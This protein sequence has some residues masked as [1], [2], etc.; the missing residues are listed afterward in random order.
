MARILAVDDE[1]T[2]TRLVEAAL[3]KD[4]HEVLSAGSGDEALL[5]ARTE[6]PDLILLDIMMPGMDGHEVLVRLRTDPATQDVPVAFLSAVGDV[7]EQL[8]GLEEGAIDYI[9]KPFSP[10]DL[11]AAVKDLLDPAL[12]DAHR[13]L[14]DKQKARL[15]TYKEVMRRK[16]EGP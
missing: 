2:I 8:E 5:K 16:S 11:R 15:R 4:G 1:P 3:A 10:V 13:K 6:E 7:S 9:T 12:A 14:V